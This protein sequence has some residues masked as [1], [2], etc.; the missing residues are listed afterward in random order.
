MTEILLKPGDIGVIN[1]STH[2]LFDPLVDAQYGWLA[3]TFGRLEG[4]RRKGGSQQILWPS[5]DQ[6]DRPGLRK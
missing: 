6:I 3:S 1:W 4:T 5:I 2:V